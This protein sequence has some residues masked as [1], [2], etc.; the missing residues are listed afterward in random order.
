M[1][2]IRGASAWLA[3]YVRQIGVPLLD[4]STLPVPAATAKAPRAPAAATTLAP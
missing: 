3:L 1:A 2:K 4:T